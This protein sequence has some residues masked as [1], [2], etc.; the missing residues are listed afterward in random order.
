[1]Y[2]VTFNLTMGRLALFRVGLSCL[3][4]SV[5]GCDHIQFKDVGCDDLVYKIKELKETEE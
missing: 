2:E 1:M 3:W 5:L 4:K